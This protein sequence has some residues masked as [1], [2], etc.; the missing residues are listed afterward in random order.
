LALFP[1]QEAGRLKT[2]L[3]GHE[4]DVLIGPRNNKG[5][6]QVVALNGFTRE[7]YRDSDEPGRFMT[8][9]RSLGRQWKAG[10]EG[11]GEDLSS[12][13]YQK[14]EPPVGR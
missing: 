14:Y 4:V 13:Y 5:L 8:R 11:K 6:C 7:Q 9:M 1:P 12:M 3:A 10:N 2:F